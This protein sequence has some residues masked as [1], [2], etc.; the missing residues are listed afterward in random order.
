MKAMVERGG[1]MRGLVERSLGLTER[2]V[3]LLDATPAGA[4]PSGG[5]RLDKRLH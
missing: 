1:S 2:P 3:P 4:D 5:N